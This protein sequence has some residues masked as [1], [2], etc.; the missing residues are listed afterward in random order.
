MEQ[1]LFDPKN[2]VWYRITLIEDDSIFDYYR[3]YIVYSIADR[4]DFKGN[5]LDVSG[6]DSS[7]NDAVKEFKELLKNI[8]SCVTQEQKKSNL[9]S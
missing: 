8:Q 5:V 3:L 1:T 6:V 4:E 9:T 2:E 7:Y